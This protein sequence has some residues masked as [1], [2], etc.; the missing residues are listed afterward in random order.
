MAEQHLVARAKRRRR[1][2]TRPGK[3]RWRPR[4]LVGRDFSAVRLNERWFGDGIEIVTGQGK[5]YL[6]SVLNICSR[7]I[8]GFSLSEHHDVELAYGALSMAAAMRG[9]DVAG[10]LLHTDGGSGYTSRSFRAA[11]ERLGVIQ[12]MGR[13]G[14]ALDNAAIEAFHFTLTFELLDLETFDTRAQA[15]RRVAAWIEEYNR[16]RRHSAVAMRA[17]VRDEL[18]RGRRS[19]RAHRAAVLAGQG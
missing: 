13:P 14:S 10:V 9:G 12:S 6:A 2:P 11:R 8:V 1:G 15:R 5:L 3:G 7:R 18:E 4:D 17:P 19:R 16:G